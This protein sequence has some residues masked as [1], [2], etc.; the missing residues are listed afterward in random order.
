M[1]RTPCKLLFRGFIGLSMG[2]YFKVLP[3]A[4]F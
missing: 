4:Q 1:E 2:P 3:T